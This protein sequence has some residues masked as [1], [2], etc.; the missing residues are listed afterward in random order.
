MKSENS[1]LN[2]LIGISQSSTSGANKS[3]QGDAESAQTIAVKHEMRINSR[4][5]ERNVKVHGKGNSLLTTRTCTAHPLTLKISNHDSV[6]NFCM[7][8]GMRDHDMS[9]CFHQTKDLV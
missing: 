2:L 7:K 5:P 1:F 6:R 3:G 8:A 9:N 4:L